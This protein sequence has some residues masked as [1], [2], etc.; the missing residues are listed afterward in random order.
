MARLIRSMV[1]ALMVIL[2]LAPAAYADN[3]PGPDAGPEAI[4]RYK[5]KMIGYT[6]ADFEARAAERQK[7]AEAGVKPDNPVIL[8]SGSLCNAGSSKNDINTSLANPGDI[9]MMTNDSGGGSYGA[10][11]HSGA[12]NGS[13]DRVIEA[14]PDPG[15]SLGYAEDFVNA[16]K[17]VVLRATSGSVDGWVVRNWAANQIGDS[18]NSN[19]CDKANRNAFYCSQLNL[20]SFK[21]TYGIDM[22]SNPTWPCDT[23]TPEELY[24]DSDNYV[25][26]S[27]D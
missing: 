27:G 11:C 20:A 8:G 5:E 25:G 16:D 9:I 6:K 13:E 7:L 18:Y 12:W 14:N 24:W 23:V 15:V 10:W 22:D 2:I 26:D 19:F 1:L 21:D 3:P 4:L 17:S